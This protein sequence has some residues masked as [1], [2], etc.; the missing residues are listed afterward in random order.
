[1]NCTGLDFS[2]TAQETT[3]EEMHRKEVYFQYDLGDVHRFPYADNSFDK[4]ISLG[5]IE[6]F[7]DNEIIMREMKRVLKQDG[8]VLLMTP[9]KFSMGRIDRLFKQLIH[10]WNFGYQ[11]EYSVKELADLCERTGFV[12]DKMFVDLRLSKKFDSTSFKIISTVDQF[13]NIFSK[14]VGFY[15]YVVLKKGS[16]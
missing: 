5:V 11:T 2:K 6:H 14:H 12:V 15:S 1:M 9:N 7:P 3:K 8:E 16:R 10:K 13:F 4:I